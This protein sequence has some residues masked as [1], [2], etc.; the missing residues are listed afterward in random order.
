MENKIKFYSL[1]PI[2]PYIIN[3]SMELMNDLSNDHLQKVIK[4][5]NKYFAF[6][7]EGLNISTKYT[8]M[9]H[10]D[11]PS[12]SDQLISRYIFSDVKCC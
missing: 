7:K 10:L 6:A 9:G 4:V 2:K 5:K 3:G 1:L 8:V 12:S 11:G